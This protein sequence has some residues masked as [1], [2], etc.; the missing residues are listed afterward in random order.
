[1]CKVVDGSP[2]L[3]IICVVGIVPQGYMIPG[4]G[5]RLSSLA[6]FVRQVLE[7]VREVYSRVVAAGVWLSLVLDS[8]YADAGFFILNLRL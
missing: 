3:G 2:C 4:W 8:D 1:M 7:V 5:G 6:F